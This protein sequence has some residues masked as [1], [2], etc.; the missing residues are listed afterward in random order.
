MPTA[1]SAMKASSVS[2]ER[3]RAPARCGRAWRQVLA[4]AHSR[5]IAAPF[6]RAQPS[7]WPHSCAIT[8]LDRRKLVIVVGNRRI[9]LL[10]E[11]FAPDLG[12]LRPQPGED[13]AALPGYRAC[14][15]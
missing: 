6:L 10:D 15:P 11:R 13:I 8:V 5:A 14:P 4:V 1:K 3:F 7:E 12:I 9:T 2:P